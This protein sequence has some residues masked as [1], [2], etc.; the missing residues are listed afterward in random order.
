VADVAHGQRLAPLFVAFKVVRDQSVGAEEGVDPFAVGAG[1][2]GGQTLRLLVSR[3]GPLARVDAR[4]SRRSERRR[5]RVWS[6]PAST[7]V[8]KIR[9]PHTQGEDAPRGMGV[10]QRRFFDLPN[11]IGGLSSCEIADH[12]GSRGIGASACRRGR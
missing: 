6:L 10:D 1:G 8:R 11:S 2:G 7:A 12:I 3:G 9:S 5:Q 4:G